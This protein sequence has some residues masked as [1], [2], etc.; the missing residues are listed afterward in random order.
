MRNHSHCRRNR[1]A[2]E[3]GCLAPSPG[4]NPG[5]AKNR[6]MKPASSSMPSDWYSEKSRDVDTNE[7][8]QRKQI[9]SMARGQKFRTRSND[10]IIPIQHS[11]INMPELLEIQSSEGAYQ[12]RT[13]A[14][15]DRATACRYSPAGR[16]PCGPI[17]P[18][19]WKTSE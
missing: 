9:R 7:R 8:K 11:A 6:E 18:R 16:I 2:R 12:T 19:I 3:G 5:G 15:P 4:R 10:A 1:P 14:T 13:C 17:N